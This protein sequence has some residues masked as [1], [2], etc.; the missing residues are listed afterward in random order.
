MNILET[1]NNIVNERSEEKDREYGPFSE[2]MQIAADIASTIR[3]KEF[4]AEDIFVALVA[5]KFS[6]EHYNHKEDNL[7]D[8]VAYVG[9]WNNF[10]N[11]REKKR[12][13][14]NI[15]VELNDK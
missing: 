1:A 11:E 4:D 2:G 14:A 13:E 8:I 7:L 15:G 3:G 5:L 10:I 9:A 6:R 12:E